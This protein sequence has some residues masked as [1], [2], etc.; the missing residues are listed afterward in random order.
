MRERR[1]IAMMVVGLLAWIGYSLWQ[2]VSPRVV[3]R[4]I[5]RDGIEMCV[6]QRFDEPFSTGFYFRKPG[7]N[8][9]WLYCD[10]EDSYWRKG[11]IEL[12][13]SNKRATVRREGKPVI[14]FDW[15]SEIY[16]AVRSGVIV[17]THKGAQNQMPQYW[18]PPG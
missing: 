14:L 7:T 5:T 13:Y 3:A 4:A 8:W 6:V 15:E 2:I 10:H 1:V 17:R 11:E 16:C 18:V 12:D 9:G